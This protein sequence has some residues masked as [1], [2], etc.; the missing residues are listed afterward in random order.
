MNDTRRSFLKK[1]SALGMG[2]PVFPL[3]SRSWGSNVNPA[4]FSEKIER[5]ELFRYD[6]DIPRHFSWGTWYNRQHLFMRISS[7]AFSGWSETPAAVNK[8]NFD[9]GEWAEYLSAFKGKR[10]TEAR[11][12]LAT[13][14]VSGTKIRSRKLEFIDM[15]L[16]DLE[17]RVSG[18][19]AV[20]LLGLDRR[21]PVPGLYCILDKDVDKAREEAEK[22]KE[23]NLGHHLKF[24]MHGDVDLDNRLL[25]VVREVLGEE[26]VIISDVNKGYKSWQSLEEL[27]SILNKF[28]KNGLNGIEDPALLETDQWIDLQ[29]QVGKLDLIPD[30]P[31]RPAWEGLERI[32]PGMGRIY[33][34]HPSTMG[35]FSAVARLAQ[36]VNEIGAKVM[37]GDDSLVGPACSAWQQ[38]AIGI[39]A[40]WVEALEK[41]ED[42]AAYHQCLVNVPTRLDDK[43]YVTLSPAPGFGIELDVGRLK[44][45]CHSHLV[46]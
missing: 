2:L 8:P 4:F 28:K 42:S 39:G 17:G 31:M 27:A 33:N 23:Q 25:S 3:V 32:Q 37:I 46:I 38:I 11:S 22:S 26:A 15:G 43:G 24:K 40:C 10:L 9:L 19:S 41:K 29:D 5:I 14:Q 30:Y 6:I 36:R 34:L 18:R 7:G 20:E 13:L 21:E 45:V 12:H 35:S 16:L 44:S 1:T